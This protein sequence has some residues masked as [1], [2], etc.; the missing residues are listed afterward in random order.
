M[1]RTMMGTRVA[2][3][4][5]GVPTPSTSLD[6]ATLK[7]GSS[8]FTVCVR[9]IATAAKERFAAMCPTACIAAGPKISPNSPLVIGCARA[10]HGGR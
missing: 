2:M 10:A 6:S 4:G 8:V 7:T 1:P 9:L 3:T 5:A